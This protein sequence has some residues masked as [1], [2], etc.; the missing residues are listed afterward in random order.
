MPFRSANPPGNDFTES[1]RSSLGLPCSYR[2]TSKYMYTSSSLHS[3][4]SNSLYTNHVS[5]IINQTKHTNKKNGR[6][7][8]TSFSFASGTRVH[9]SERTCVGHTPARYVQ[10]KTMCRHVC[11]AMHVPSTETSEVTGQRS[12]CRGLSV[13]P[14][15]LDRSTVWGI[16][17]WWLLRFKHHPDTWY[18]PLLGW[19]ASMHAKVGLASLGLAPPPT[20]GGEHLCYGVSVS[21]PLIFTPL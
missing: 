19:L 4:Q 13:S 7:N 17:H 15:G 3:K 6:T 16:S 18:T 9:K 8:P 12:T 20:L 1:I 14:Y 10:A 5:L 21:A 11:V 2:R